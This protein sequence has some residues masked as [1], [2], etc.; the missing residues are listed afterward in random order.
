MCW[1][2]NEISSSGISLSL[3]IYALQ[4]YLHLFPIKTSDILLSAGWRGYCVTGR[5]RSW[6]NDYRSLCSASSCF[7]FYWKVSVLFQKPI[8]LDN[9]FFFWHGF[10]V[11]VLFS[12]INSKSIRNAISECLPDHKLAILVPVLERFVV[13]NLCN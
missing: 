4:R 9:I 13:R 5:E 3:K 8:F 1:K 2:T 12:L 11:E 10:S 6:E 7:P